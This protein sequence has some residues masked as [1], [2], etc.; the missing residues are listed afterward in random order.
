M[1]LAIVCLLESTPYTLETEFKSG[2]IVPEFIV[3]PGDARMQDAFHT[4]PHA[5]AHV[6]FLV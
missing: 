4:L 6:R 5:R 3:P 2:R 1:S